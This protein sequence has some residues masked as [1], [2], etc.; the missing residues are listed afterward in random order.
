[1]ARL[2]PFA[3]PP[4]GLPD[5]HVLCP[6]S[7]SSDKAGSQVFTLRLADFDTAVIG[8]VLQASL[9]ERNALQ[10]CV[11]YFRQKARPRVATSERQV[12]E[13][14]LDASSQAQLP[15]TLR[16]LRERAAERAPRSTEFF[17]YSGLTAKL[18][19]LWQSGVFDQAN[20]PPLDPVRMLV[21][22]RVTILDVSV[23]NDVVKNMV[24][25]DLLQKTFAVKLNQPQ[26]PPTLLVIEEAHSFIS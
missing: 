2:A 14:L 1:A 26:A 4:A 8:E 20:L 15:F 5:C 25:A 3:R 9:P 11:E 7:C 10:D 22:G 24:T 19:W 6:A 12:H 18:S 21:P 23:A 13:T 16:S 17:D